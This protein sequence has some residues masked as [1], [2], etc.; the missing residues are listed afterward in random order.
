[1]LSSC[2]YLLNTLKAY[3]ILQYSMPEKLSAY[4]CAGQP[5]RFSG[6]GEAENRIPE[7]LTN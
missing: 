3:D 6:I 1:M 5:L 4:S 7:P 2:Q